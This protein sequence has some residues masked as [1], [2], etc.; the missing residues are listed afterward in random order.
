[1]QSAPANVKGWIEPPPSA[2]G[3]DELDPAEFEGKLTHEV[4]QGGYGTGTFFIFFP[5]AA[6][7]VPHHSSPPS[8]QG[9]VALPHRSG[10]SGQTWTRER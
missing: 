2:S 4:G 7:A 3:W 8:L 6:M 10:E 5:V 9:G 1:M